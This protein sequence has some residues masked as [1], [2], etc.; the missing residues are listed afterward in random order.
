MNPTDWKSRAGGGRGRWGDPPI[1]GHD[2]SGVV[3]ACGTGAS[4]FPPG[5][6]V[7]GMPHFPDQG[8]G[9]AEYVAASVAALR[10]QAGGAEPPWRRRRCRSSG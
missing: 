8:G 7:Y 4:L 5:D 3:V 9:Y 10:P 1:L 2:V 6:E